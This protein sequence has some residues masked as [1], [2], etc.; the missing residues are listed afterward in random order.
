MLRCGESK[1]KMDQKPER[2]IEK[3][4]PLPEFIEKL[5]RL[6]DALEKDQRFEIQIAGERILVP[7]RAT[8]LAAVVNAIKDLATKLDDL[9]NVVANF[10]K[11]V[12]TKRV[13]TEQ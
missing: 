4:Y 10:A 1:E 2:D 6:A 8:I 9:S 5:R 3:D 11:S 13:Q 7:V 12:T